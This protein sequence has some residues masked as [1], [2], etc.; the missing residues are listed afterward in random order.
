MMIVVMVGVLLLFRRSNGM[1]VFVIGVTSVQ[2]WFHVAV[3]VGGKQQHAIRSKLSSLVI[4]LASFRGICGG[5]EIARHSR[6]FARHV[7]LRISPQARIVQTR[8]VPNFYC[9]RMC[10]ANCRFDLSLLLFKTDCSS[11]QATLQDDSN[12][13]SLSMPFQPGGC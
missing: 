2:S 8:R 12:K 13:S 11:S 7:R 4:V 5:Q 3:L 6:R 1:T 9:E 10:P